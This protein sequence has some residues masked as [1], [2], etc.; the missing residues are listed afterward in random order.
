MD[1]GD[2]NTASQFCSSELCVDKLADGSVCDE[3]G[4]SNHMCQS[5]VCNDNVL[6]ATDETYEHCV[7]CL[8]DSHCT[9]QQFSGDEESC[10]PKLA[11]GESCSSNEM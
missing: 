5:G 10:V 4:D 1:H 9:G 6:N 11:N 3:T 8:E 2:C 7:E